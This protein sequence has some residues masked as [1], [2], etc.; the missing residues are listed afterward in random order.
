MRRK[1]LRV[2]P[3]R[4]VHG[5]VTSIRFPVRH[6]P[7]AGPES[8][9]SKR[10]W[11]Q[12]K[13]WLVHGNFLLR[14]HADVLTAISTFDLADLN[15]LKTVI[16]CPKA[17]VSTV[18]VSK[19]SAQ[20]KCLEIAPKHGNILTCNTVSVYVGDA[21]LPHRKRCSV[22]GPTIFKPRPLHAQDW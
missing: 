21:L 13:L 1:A 5:R 8:G 16:D 22:A 6:W 18:R 11:K 7:G 20:R 10:L 17:I 14:E 2:C 15:D 3:C 19:R 12:P 4:V 9:G